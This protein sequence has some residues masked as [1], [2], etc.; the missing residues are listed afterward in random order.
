[1]SFSRRCTGRPDAAARVAVPTDYG[2]AVSSRGV[3]RCTRA[4]SRYMKS[5]QSIMGAMQR[6]WA[7]Y[8]LGY[9]KV[10][11]PMLENEMIVARLF[12]PFSPVSHRFGIPNRTV[13]IAEMARSW[14]LRRGRRFCAVQHCRPFRRAAFFQS[15][16]LEQVQ[17]YRGRALRQLMAG[18][19]AFSHAERKFDASSAVS[20]VRS[21]A[22]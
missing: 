16:T 17:P 10:P 1:M 6:R 12:S 4:R 15:L 8:L 18:Q 3:P 14:A 2:V 7:L 21:V 19:Y 5:V 13:F 20:A 9:F 11:S 22:T